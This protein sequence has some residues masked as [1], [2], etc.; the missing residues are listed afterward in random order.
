M[1][2]PLSYREVCSL[3]PAC[4]PS[5]LFFHLHTPTHHPNAGRHL[6]KFPAHGSQPDAQRATAG[7][8][9]RPWHTGTPGS[10]HAPPTPAA[11][12]I[13][14]PGQGA[15]G[16]TPKVVGV[17]GGW[18]PTPGL[19][20]SARCPPGWGAPPKRGPLG[21][22]QEN[23]WQPALARGQAWEGGG[24]PAPQGREQSLGISF[25]AGP[26][27]PPSAPPSSSRARARGHN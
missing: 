12:S 16:G 3:P 21:R 24:P 1:Q 6:G 25:L 18:A 27:C 4:P 10:C 9:T 13:T 22:Y 17:G 23:R 7:L 14:Q 11:L 8:A 5:P 20:S 15:G 2:S 19:C 26:G